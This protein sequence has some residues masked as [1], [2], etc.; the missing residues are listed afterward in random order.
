MLYRSCSFFTYFAEHADIKLV[1]TDL[2]WVFTRIWLFA[3]ENLCKKNAKSVYIRLYGK[4]SRCKVRTRPSAPYVSKRMARCMCTE[5]KASVGH[6]QASFWC[7]NGQDVCGLPQ[8]RAMRE[9]PVVETPPRRSSGAC[10]QGMAF[11]ML[12]CEKLHHGFMN[13]HAHTP[14]ANDPGHNH[15][16][17]LNNL[18]RGWNTI[19]NGVPTFPKRFFWESPVCVVNQSVSVC[20]WTR[21]KTVEATN[22]SLQ[23][24]LWSSRWWARLPTCVCMYVCKYVCIYVCMYVC[25]LVCFICM[26]YDMHVC[27][28]V[29]IYIYIYIHHIR[30]MCMHQCAMGT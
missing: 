18:I 1:S 2:D 30:M 3:W 25:M 8:T 17:S 10:T 6:I 4:D 12:W 11:V 22:Q 29:F 20:G 14:Y 16:N 21:D 26:M 27:I 7:I 19:Q 24:L 5:G 9:S 15:A 28:Y 13:N 23:L